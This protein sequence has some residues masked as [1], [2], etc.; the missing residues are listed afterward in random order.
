[1]YVEERAWYMYV[2]ESNLKLF[3]TPLYFAIL[4]SPRQETEDGMILRE[5]YPG[6]RQPS[7]VFWAVVQPA[8][9]HQRITGC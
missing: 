9:T 4:S 5:K 7:S 8:V 6:G 2:D 3:E 1:M